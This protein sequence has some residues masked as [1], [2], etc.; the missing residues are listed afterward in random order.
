MKKQQRHALQITIQ[1]QVSLQ[2]LVYLPKGYH[3]SKQKCPFVLFLHGRGERG[4]NLEL[5]THHGIPKLIEEGADFPFILVSPQCSENRFWAYEVDTLYALI[6]QIIGEYRVDTSRIYLTGLSMG[7]FGTWHLAAAYP[8]LFAA[9]IPICGG[10]L[11]YSDFPERIKILKDVPVWVFH[12]AQDNIVPVHMSQE[13]VDVLRDHNGSVRFT[14]Y[15][16][17]GHDSWTQTYKNP[18]LYNWLLQQKNERFNMA[19]TLSQ[20]P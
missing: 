14:I 16:D 6:E 18:E 19:D 11:P 2:Y 20:E 15:P 10:T 1:K 5:V 12:G 4:A 8:R 13:L 17:A 3:H 7:G 9:I